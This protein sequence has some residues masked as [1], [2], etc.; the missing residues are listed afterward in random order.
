VPDTVV[1]PDG[2]VEGWMPVRDGA[3]V[4]CQP[5]GCQSVYPQNNVP[6]DKATFDSTITVPARMSGIGN[7][8]LAGQSTS[9]GRTT[10][11]WH[12]AQPIP[13]YLTTVT[14]GDYDLHQTTDAHGR[15]IYDFVD[16]TFTPGDKTFA[17]TRLAEAPAVIDFLTALYGP[18]PFDSYGA[19]VAEA[20]FVGY[21]LEVATRP[22]YPG[23]LISSTTQAHELAHQWYGDSL[24]YAQIQDL[25][26]QEGMA[27]W[28]EWYWYNQV[29][30]GPT[31]EQEFDD[32]YDDPSTHWSLPPALPTAQTLFDRQVYERGAMTWD[33][34]RQIV[35]DSAF[36]AFVAHLVD[37]YKYGSITT[38]DFL[39]E[40]KVA[41]P[42]H[43]LD[44]FFQDY[45]FTP[46]RPPRPST[47][48]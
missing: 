30:G 36:F 24:T 40:A 15:P 1:D 46:G 11:R 7:G 19:I 9:G 31:T 18:Y 35:G 25:W 39:Q 8:T 17:A 42:A 26:I 13:T 45:L 28:L 12:M 41:F 43:N 33:G 21:A 38:A 16:A 48:P 34:L 6:Y 37:R 27:Q 20:G 44:R 14:V 47:Y 3:V 22:F 5:I 29:R 32:L 4:A 2:S 10:W 23:A